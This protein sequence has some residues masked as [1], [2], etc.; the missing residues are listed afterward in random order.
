LNLAL[1]ESLA[2]D[3]RDLY[4]LPSHGKRIPTAQRCHRLDRLFSDAENLTG[5]DHPDAWRA[6]V[7]AHDGDPAAAANTVAAA[8]ADVAPSE[9]ASQWFAARV[10]AA[11][12]DVARA[13]ND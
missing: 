7:A 12:A 1:A 6:I 3:A 2:A 5:R 11:L 10:A 8:L 13:D 4:R 9:P